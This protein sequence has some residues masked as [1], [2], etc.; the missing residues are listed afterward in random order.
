MTRKRGMAT[1]DRWVWGLE[2][3]VCGQL[4]SC[5]L[6]VGRSPFAG[7]FGGGETSAVR[8]ILL[9]FASFSWNLCWSRGAESLYS[10]RLI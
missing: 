4:S 9:S 1:P 2:F 3:G 10:P 5:S 6:A 8:P 7:P